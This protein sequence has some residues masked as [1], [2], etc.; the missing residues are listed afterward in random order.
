MSF[1]LR[2]SYA[3][4]PRSGDASPVV[5]ANP[6]RHRRSARA[7]GMVE[8]ALIGPIFIMFLLAFVDLGRAV[9]INHELANGTR[10]AAR[11][12]MVNGTEDRYPGD[13]VLTTYLLSKTTG[14]AGGSLT[15]TG[16]GAG[17]VGE[18]IT[19]H[20][21]YT[22]TPIFAEIIGRGAIPM[23]AQSRVVIQR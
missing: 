16:S 11:Y 5:R 15:V 10:E 14:I 22:F 1:D 17:E 19:V 8:F 18:F 7:Q 6:S 4:G 2:T 3:R 9:W 23:S 20:S 13:D 21:S 12:A